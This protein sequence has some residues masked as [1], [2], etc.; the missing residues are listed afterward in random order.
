M[1]KALRNI[2]S[3]CALVVAGSAHAGIPTFDAA[4]V[5][6]AI[7]Q[8]QS[9]AQQYQQMVTQIRNMETQI[10]NVTGSR[11]FSSLLNGPLYEQAR[12]YLPAD[13]QA[14]VDAMRSANFGTLNSSLESVKRG[15]VSLS[16]S[17]FKSSTAGTQFDQDMNRAAM[18]HVSSQ[19]AYKAA[20][21]RLQGL[22]Y[23]TGQISATN[24]PKAIAELQARIATEQ[25][26]I[27]NETAK[28]QSL[29]MLIAAEKQISDM[30]A[31]QAA[32]RMGGGTPVFQNIQFR[33]AR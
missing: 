6:Q 25:S 26:M 15:A 27:Q 1:K 3:A 24:D 11:G 23:M 10:S 31:K 33:A 17:Q 12:R 2:F 5:A 18:A 29:Q 32:M 19:E 21:Q 4:A 22:E 16:G 13:S 7:M 28:L 30:Q 14:L 20:M 9:W 8:V